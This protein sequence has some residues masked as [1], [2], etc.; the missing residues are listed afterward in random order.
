MESRK[1]VVITISVSP[2]TAREYRR[3]AESEGES[4][5]K[6]FREMFAFYKKEKL[7]KELSDIQKYG[8]G[9]AGQLKITP[10]NIEK[11]IFADR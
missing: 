6:F 2:E 11:L 3:L 9:K 8:A 1:R 10:E 5:S 4:I 7:R